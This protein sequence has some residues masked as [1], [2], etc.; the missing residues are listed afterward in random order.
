MAD[1][2]NEWKALWDNAQRKRYFL[3]CVSTTLLVAI[4]QP[5]LTGQVYGE[6]QSIELLSSLKSSSLYFGNALATVSATILALMLTLLSMTHKLD[7][8]FD[9]AIY[10]GIRLVGLISTITFVVSLV[11]LLCLSLPVGE[12]ENIPAG[13]YKGL[14]YTI[15]TLNIL[16]SG[17]MIIGVLVLF[18]TISTLINKLAP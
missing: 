1:R 4:A 11:L 16:L 12:F 8:E 14:Y 17:L 15:S 10:R 18:D 9:G 6:T 2:N 5:V 3:I 13:W 7:A